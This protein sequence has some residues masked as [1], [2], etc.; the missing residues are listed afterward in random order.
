MS[1]LAVPTTGSD[2]SK[3]NSERKLN[4]RLDQTARERIH[5]TSTKGRIAR[6]RKKYIHATERGHYKALIIAVM[7][8]LMKQR[9]EK[10]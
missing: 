1:R 2:P 6:K 9:Q 10:P 3:A 5:V 8:D 7:N 4:K